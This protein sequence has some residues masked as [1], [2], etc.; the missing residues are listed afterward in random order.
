MDLVPHLWEAV[1]TGPAEVIVEFHQPLSLETA[2]GRKALALAAE[3]IVRRGQARALAGLIREDAQT[4][5]Q[6]H[7]SEDIEMAEVPA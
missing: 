3:K 7:R 5:G 2:G 1:K 4:V 6:E